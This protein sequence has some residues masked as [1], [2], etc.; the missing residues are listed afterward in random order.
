MSCLYLECAKSLRQSRVRQGF[1]LPLDGFAKIPGLGVGRGKGVKVHGRLPAGKLTGSGRRLHGFG[2]VA[3]AAAPAR[4][5]AGELA[6]CEPPLNEAEGGWLDR[7]RG[8]RRRIVAPQVDPP[9]FQV[10]RTTVGSAADGLIEVVERLVEF[11][12]FKP[13]RTIAVVIFDEPA[14]GIIEIGLVGVVDRVPQ[15][16][17]GN[18]QAASREDIE[19][20]S[21]DDR[22]GLCDLLLGR[23]A[24]RASSIKPPAPGICLSTAANSASSVD[25]GLANLLALSIK[26]QSMTVHAAAGSR[27]CSR[28]T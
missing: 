21:G 3:C 20:G 23:T 8:A 7:G 19:V 13:G 2:S 14:I 6:G 11:A 27:P 28:P 1:F 9:P 12:G 26:S 4:S 22:L 10:E 24:L 5:R 18:P 16:D 15:L 25:A 17:N